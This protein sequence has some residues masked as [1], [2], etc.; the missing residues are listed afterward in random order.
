MTLTRRTLLQ[1]L[2]ALL[3]LSALGLGRAPT[4]PNSRLPEPAEGGGVSFRDLQNVT[5]R[6]MKESMQ[7]TMDE[8]VDEAWS[9]ELASYRGYS[10][11]LTRGVK[12]LKLEEP[13]LFSTG[14]EVGGAFWG[15]GGCA[16]K[17]FRS[18]GG[19]KNG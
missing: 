19:R 14:P 10:D 9:G 13:D 15:K 4:L 16:D 2:A 11:N 17:V 8:M 3:P 18:Y 6:A 12:G 7:A 1:S 5:A